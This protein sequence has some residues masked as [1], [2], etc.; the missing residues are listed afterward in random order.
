M[1]E[2]TLS[3]LRVGVERARLQ[4]TQREVAEEAGVT[5]ETVANAERGQQISLRTAFAI[6]RVLNRVRAEYQEPPLTLEDFS[7][8]IQKT[9]DQQP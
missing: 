2:V 1:L 6:L 4:L 5:R 8:H 9:E 3:K 7:W